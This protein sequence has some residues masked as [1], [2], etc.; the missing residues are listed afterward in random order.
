MAVRILG[1]PL[2]A[3]I[4]ADACAAW[5]EVPQAQGCMSVDII[6]NPPYTSGMSERGCQHGI[7]PAWFEH[8]SRARALTVRMHCA[9]FCTELACVLMRG[10]WG[11]AGVFRQ[12][13]A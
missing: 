7:S 6:I 9:A 12:A 3:L 4:I 1:P 8:R 2:Q 10:G 13:S 5:R 11:R